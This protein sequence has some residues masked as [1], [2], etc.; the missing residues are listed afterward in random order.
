MPLYEYRCRECEREF[1]LLV[2]RQADVAAECPSCRSSRVDRLIGLPA[3]G[4]V[5]EATPATNCRGDGAPCGAPR[6][7]RKV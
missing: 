4:R 5:V 2:T 1:E 7:G 6:C 3:R